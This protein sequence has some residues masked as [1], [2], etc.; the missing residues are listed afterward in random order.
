LA[1]LV[2][3]ITLYLFLTSRL[4]IVRDIIPAGL[5]G[6]IIGLCTTVPIDSYFWQSFPLWPE[7]TAF[8][9]NTIQGHSADWGVSPWHFYFVNA[10]PRL[11]LN[12]LTYLL[13]IPIALLS[14]ATRTRSLDLLIPSLAFVTIYSLLPHKE[15]RFII[16]IVPALTGIAAAGSSYLWT[17]RGK[18][19]VYTLLS[20][21]LVAGVLASFLASSFLLAIS[22]LNYPGGAGMSVL[23]TRFST[24]ST[25]TPA[26]EN[27]TVNRPLHVHFDNLACQTGVTRFLEDHTGASTILDILDPESQPPMEKEHR[28]RWIY[29]KTEAPERLL[30]PL[31]WTQFDY[32]LAER[33]EKVIGK[34][35]VVHT[36]YGFSG[37]RV[38]R[39]G[40]ESRAGKRDIEEGGGVGGDDV[41]EGGSDVVNE[42]ARLWRALEGLLREK[43][44]RGWW[45]EVGLEPRLR[46]LRN[47]MERAEGV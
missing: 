8:Y 37:I 35:D 47:A 43:V 25:S 41:E 45:V 4:S 17:R 12:P 22:A 5:S 24:P 36:E 44:F 30:D 21:A 7:W 18:S 16:Y 34:W 28:R 2:G 15:W 40:V 11:L 19:L 3:T 13:C 46:I 27:T 14:P 20:L 9:Y 33:P 31:F 29:D 26:A 10:I 39:P 38:L 1:I 32:V 42:I 6:L 23:H